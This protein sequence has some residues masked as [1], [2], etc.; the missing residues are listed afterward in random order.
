MAAAPPQAP[1]ACG[2]R[3]HNCAAR[4]CSQAASRASRTRCAGAAGP[5]AAG[6]V[7]GA[8]VTR[9]RAGQAT[10]GLFQAVEER[11]ARAAERDPPQRPC[12]A[13]EAPAGRA[14]G[15]ACAGADAGARC[16]PNGACEAADD[17]AAVPAGAG[18]ARADGAG[19]G[20]ADGARADA[21]GAGGGGAGSVGVDEAG[22]GVLTLAR[23]EWEALALRHLAAHTDRL[24]AREDFALACRRAR[25]PPPTQRQ[26]AIRTHTAVPTGVSRCCPDTGVG[27]CCVSRT[28][29]SAWRAEA[30]PA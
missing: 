7:P 22:R 1:A 19:R 5:A 15:R 21:D 4:C 23:A 17:G 12:Q 13:G 2:T 30:Q 10:K 3:P 11:L 20:G 24:V 27:P 14:A 29:C 18:G 8:A 6:A 26:Q 16:A 28:A 9:P 25:G